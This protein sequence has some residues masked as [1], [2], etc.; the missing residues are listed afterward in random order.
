V[1]PA[2]PTEVTTCLVRRGGVRPIALRRPVPL[3][4][5]PALCSA[6]SA[7]LS[8]DRRTWRRAQ[9]GCPLR[10]FR[11]AASVSSGAP[12]GAADRRSSA[13][14]TLTSPSVAPGCRPEGRRWLPGKGTNRSGVLLVRSAWPRCRVVGYPDRHSSP[15]HGTCW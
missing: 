12:R 13:V 2:R 4:A 5:P 9:S 10:R 3:V 14:S 8:V 7:A 1:L 11:S 6:R 15:L